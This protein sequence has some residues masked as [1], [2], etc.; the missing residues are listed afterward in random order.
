MPQTREQINAY[1][2]AYYAKNRD[3]IKKYP[4]YL[5]KET[6]RKKWR[7]RPEN[8]VKLK[9]SRKRAAKTYRAKNIAWLREYKQTLQCQNCG[10]TDSLCLDFHHRDPKTK[11]F[12]VRDGVN[13]GIKKMLEEIAKCDVLCCNCHRKLTYPHLV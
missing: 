7:S 3:K 9:P 2:R 6:A 8:R 1:Q 4:S 12:N 11:L 13:R 10:E 5:N